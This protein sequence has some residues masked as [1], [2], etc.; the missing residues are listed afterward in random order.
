[1]TRRS[2]G[3]KPEPQRRRGA[4]QYVSG[5]LRADV[6][7]ELMYTKRGLYDRASTS[8]SSGQEKVKQVSP[9]CLPGQRIRGPLA[10]RSLRRFGRL[11]TLSSA[12]SKLAAVVWSALGPP[13]TGS[14]PGPPRI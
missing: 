2:Q 3:I 5:Y 8:A 4:D 13:P 10:A 11:W 7:A 1:M 9:G 14:L 6:G 12:R